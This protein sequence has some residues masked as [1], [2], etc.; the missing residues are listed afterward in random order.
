VQSDRKAAAVID[1]EVV[2]TE[3]TIMG[4]L[5]NIQTLR[6]TNNEIMTAIKTALQRCMG[7][8]GGGGGGNGGGG[9]GGGGKIRCSRR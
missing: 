6:I 5:E 2:Y 1:G 9:G 7:G 8:G 3:E 4:N